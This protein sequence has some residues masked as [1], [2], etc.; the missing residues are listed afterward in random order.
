MGTWL[1]E[2][3]LMNI[4]ATP[5]QPPPRRNASSALARCGV[6]AVATLRTDP[7]IRQVVGVAAVFA[8]GDVLQA[9]AETIELALAALGVAPASAYAPAPREVIDA[10]FEDDE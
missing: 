9:P 7:V 2:A 1:D 3:T 6:P 4:E 8:T 10:T 5:P